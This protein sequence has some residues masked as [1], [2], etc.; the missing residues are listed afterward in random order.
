MV[1]LV[2]NKLD[3][4]CFDA[5]IGMISHHNEMAVMHALTAVSPVLAFASA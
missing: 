5:L 3:A 4:D 1:K 2:P